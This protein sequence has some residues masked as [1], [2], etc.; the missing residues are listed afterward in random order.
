MIDLSHRLALASEEIAG[1][2]IDGEAI[3]MHLGTGAYY[4]MNPVASRIWELCEQGHPL[5]EVATSI[6]RSFSVDSDTAE[7]DVLKLAQELVEEGLLVPSSANGT[8]PTPADPQGTG[9]E[10]ATPEL[11]KYSDM[12]ELLALDPPMPGVSETPWSEPQGG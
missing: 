4:S 10:Y 12:A 9:R 8:H 11:E 6:S 3:V 2:V 1:K 7:A 5:A